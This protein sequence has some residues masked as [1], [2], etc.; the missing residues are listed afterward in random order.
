[1]DTT[2]L[3]TL[4][5]RYL[6]QAPLQD[7][8]YIQS[9]HSEYEIM[10]TN[11]YGCCFNIKVIFEEHHSKSRL[12]RTFSERRFRVGKYVAQFFKHTS[13]KDN[14][15]PQIRLPDAYMELS[16]PGIRKHSGTNMLIDSLLLRLIKDI[17]LHIS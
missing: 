14:F 4:R 9:I 10:D 17:Q 2:V 12:P 11:W 3:F 8:Q 13:L 5:H 16:M 1:M 15:S 6:L 7:W